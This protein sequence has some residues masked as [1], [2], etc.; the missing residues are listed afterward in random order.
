MKDSISIFHSG[1]C[2]HSQFLNSPEPIKDLLPNGREI[3]K[4]PASMN[5]RVKTIYQRCQ[6]RGKPSSELNQCDTDFQLN[7][8]DIE[9]NTGDFIF[10]QVQF[11]VLTKQKCRNGYI[12]ID[13]FFGKIDAGIGG[14]HV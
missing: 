5:P 11:N 13:R 1:Y 3:E 7:A 4:R 9:G 14:E 6:I 2:Q 8:I 10:I 12:N